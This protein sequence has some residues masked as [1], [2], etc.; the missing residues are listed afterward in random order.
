VFKQISNS[1]KIDKYIIL[2]DYIFFLWCYEKKQKT[3][4]QYQWKRS[5]FR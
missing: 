5:G 1:F 4:R 2:T 3:H